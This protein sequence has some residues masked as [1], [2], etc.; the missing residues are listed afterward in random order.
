MPEIAG[1]PIEASFAGRS[2]PPVPAAH[3]ERIHA[4]AFLRQRRIVFEKA[5]ERDPRELARIFTHELF[6]FAW[7]RMGNPRRRSYERLVA[8]EMRAGVAGELGWSAEYRKDALSPRDRS[9]RTRRWRE[10]VCESFCDSAAWLFSGVARHPEFTLPG[11]A[12]RSRRLWFEQADV[13]RRISV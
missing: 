1:A 11:P 6:H 12:Q 3:F 2:N 13:T 8:R 10:Y 5:L 9:G 4:G 7:Y